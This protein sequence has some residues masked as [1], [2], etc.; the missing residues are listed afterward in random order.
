MLLSALIIITFFKYVPYKF[1]R[2]FEGSNVKKIITDV[3]PKNIRAIRCY[4]KA[5][6]K[7]IGEI[8][9]PD[10]TTLLMEIA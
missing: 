8:N 2:L 9:T 3:N 1:L 4:E 6:F 7:R 5:G 10:G